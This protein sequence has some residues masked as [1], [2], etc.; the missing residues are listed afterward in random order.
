MISQPVTVVQVKNGRALVRWT[1]S[2][3]SGCV[4][5]CGS[6]TRQARELWVAAPSDCE[7]GDRCRLVT[8]EDWL[9]QAAATAY[10]IPLL[11]LL[12]GVVAGAAWVP[13]AWQDIGA[14]VGAIIG[15]ALAWPYARAAA[16]EPELLPCTR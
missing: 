5:P 7:S 11:A 3:C 6:W 1:P 9:L 12:V 15:L 14:L 10:G 8:S 2:T 4:V 13:S 16:P